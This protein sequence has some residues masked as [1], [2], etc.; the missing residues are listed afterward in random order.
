MLP[1]NLFQGRDKHKSSEDDSEPAS[2]RSLDEPK[3]TFIWKYRSS[4][5]VFM[6]KHEA[7]NQFKKKKKHLGM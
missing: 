7:G 4:V 1:T 3:K 6:W 5:P 2:R